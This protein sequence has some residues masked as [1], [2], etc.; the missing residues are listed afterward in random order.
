MAVTFTKSDLQYLLTQIVAAENG[1]PPLNP[2]LAFGLRELA[3]TNNNQLPGQST[4]GSADQPFPTATKQLFQTV[5]VNVDGTPFDYDLLNDGTT[6]TTTYAETN[7]NAFGPPAH[8]VNVVDAAPRMISNLIADISQNNPAAVAVAQAFALQL[9]DGYTA[10]NTNPTGLILPGADGKFGTADDQWGAGADG[11]FGNDDD[12]WG[13]DGLQGTTDD[14]A[15]RD[16]DNLFIGNIVPDA[17]LSAPFNNWMTF[18]GQFFDHGLDLIS[19]GGNGYV[20]IPLDP[21]DPLYVPGGHTNFMLLER[22]SDVTVLPG[23]DGKLGTADD[24]HQFTNQVSP[25]VDQN[26]TYA[27]DGSHNAF[28]REYMIGADGRLHSTGKMLEHTT[29][30]G[31]D[32]IKGDNQATLVDESLDD[33]RDG[34]A[35]WADLKANAL[36]FGL[37][38]TDYDVKNVPL[39]A[40]DAYG[41]LILDNTGH[42]QLLV[43]IAGTPTQVPLNPLAPQTL[44]QIATATGGAVMFTGHAFINDMAH[45]ASPFSSSGAPL[46]AD[47]DSTTGLANADASPTAGFYDNELLDAHYMAGDGR[48]NENIALTTVHEVFHSEHNRLIDQV[49]AMVQAELN[50]GDTAFATDWVLPGTVL[51]PG[52]NI[53]D[54]QWNGERLMQ[55]AKFGTETQYQHLV[56]E[57]FARKIAPTIHLFGNVDIHLD[58]AITSEFANAVYRFGHSMLDENVPLYQMNPDG[59]MKIGLDGKPMLTDM[60]L[61]QAFTNPLAFAASPDIAG[62]VV[63]GTTHQIGSE[64]DEFV[65][66]ALRNNLLGLP[67][68]LAALNIARGRDTGVAPLNLVRAQIYDATHDQTL[69]PYSNWLEFGQFLK[70]PESLVNFIAAY[71]THATITGVTDLNAKRAAALDLIT[72]GLDPMSK[73][74]DPTHVDAY[75]FMH[76]L[77]LYAN[78]VNNAMAVHA[79]WSTGSV[80]GVDNIDLWMGGL[81]EKQN[82]FGG[83]LGST[84]NFIFETQLENLQD[85]DRFYYLP[86]IEG[87]D[88]GQQIENNSFADMIIANTGVKHIS[89]AIFMTPEYTIEAKDVTDNP[90][91]WLKNPVTGQYIVEKLPDGTVHFIG[92]DNFFGNTMVLGGTDGD[93]RLQAGMADDDTVWG[94]GGNDWID[95]GNGDDFLYGGDGDDTFVDSAGADV[96]H[97]NDGNDTVYAG[98]GDDIVFGNDGNDYVE[99]GAGIDDIVGGAGNDILKGGEDDD[100]ILGNEGDDWIEGGDGGDNLVGDTGAPTGQVPLFAANDVLD[101]GTNGDKMVGFSGDD[102]MLGQGGFDKFYG[103]LGFDWASFEKETH[104][105]SVDME[106]RE[107]VANPVAPA[108]DAI[109]DFFIETEAASGSKFDDFIQGTEDAGR[110]AGVFNELQ[111]LDL[112]F[113]LKTFF[114]GGVA[115]DWDT[116]GNP[117]AGGNGFDN[118]NILLGGDGNDVITGR[119]GNDIIDGDAYLHVALSGNGG[120]GSEIIREI[121]WDTT[122]GDVDTAVFRDVMANYTINLTPDENGFITVTHNGTV[123][124]VVAGVRIPVNEGTD[125]LRNIERL[126][127]ADQTISIDDSLTANSLPTGTLTVIGD[128]IPGTPIID[129]VVGSPLTAVS[130]LTDP[131]GLFPGTTVHFQWQQQVITAGGGQTWIDIAG[132]TGLNFTP[133]N[134]Q[135][136]NALRVVESWKDGLGFTET[137]ASPAT[138]LL[139][140]NL[141]VNTAPFLVPQQ[142]LFGL[143]DTNAKVGIPINLLLPLTSVFGDN[144]TAPANLVYTATLS[145]GASLASVG[146]TFTLIPD[147]LG[148]VTGARITGSVAN[149]GAIAIKITATD[150]GNPAIP[151]VDAASLSTTDTFLINVQSA[152]IPPTVSAVQED[153]TGFE[154]INRSGTLLP[155]SDA[156]GPSPLLFK[157]VQGSA[158]NGTVQING[159]TGQFLFKPT[160]DFAGDATFK[161]YVTDGVSNSAQKTVTVHFNAVDDGAA[162]V[163]ITGTAASGGTLSAVIGVDPDGAYDLST[164][165]YQWF[166]DGVALGGWTNNPDLVLSDGDIGHQFSVS[167]KYTDAQGF[168]DS[169]TSV[170]TAPVGVVKVIPT[171]GATTP[172]L[173]VEN[174]LADPDGGPLPDGVTYQWEVST[175]GVNWAAAPDAEVSFDTLTFTPSVTGDPGRYVRVTAVYIDGMGFLNTAMSMAQHY[176]VDTTATNPN[177]ITGLSVSDYI[178]GNGGSDRINAGA[179][180]DFALG[181]AGNDRF[182]ATVGDG[183]DVYDGGAGTDTYDLGLTSAAADVNLVTGIATSADI[184]TDTL[185]N[186]ENV[187][188]SNG[189]NALTGNAGANRL[190]GRGGND[191]LDGGSAGADVLV[192]GT[193]DD[194]YIVSHTGMTLTELAGAAQ[195]VD[196]VQSSI[197]FALGANFENLTLTGTANINGTGNSG[198]NVIIGNSGNNV[199]TGGGGN[200]NIQGGDG[201]DTFAASAPV[202]P[203]TND[204]NDTYNG[205][206]G[207]DTLDLSAV[208]GATIVNL[209]AGTATGAVIG[210]DTLISIENVIG[211]NGADTITGSAVDNVFT[212]RGGGDSISGGAGNDRF[213]ATAADGG[214]TYNGGADFDTLDMSAITQAVTVNLTLASGQVTGAQVGTDTV[215][216]IERFIG[217]SA[218]DV[219][220]AGNQVETFTGGAGADRFVFGSIAAAGNGAAARTVITDFG[221]LVDK[222]DLRPFDANTTVAG[223]Q[224]FNFVAAAGAALAPGQVGFRYEFDAFGQEHT[225]VEGNVRTALVDPTVTDFQID[226]VGHINLTATDFILV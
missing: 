168:D 186:I 43:N 85:G 224:A 210:N 161:Y 171:P 197:S 91:T 205:G 112:I 1:Q 124:G 209:D 95:G 52:T 193:G 61:I 127:F 11:K 20:Y 66:G 10:M 211:N 19:K 226:L 177:I 67:L 60:G 63:Q 115:A 223:V 42:V 96:V 82:L 202:A 24:I 109:R 25:F 3:G 214:D 64:I 159:T 15:P 101:G 221:H 119:A 133:T 130:T 192:G 187:D 80:T 219:F 41:N 206:S 49:K 201:N 17:G 220:T 152:N 144:E 222:I 191:I 136:G 111:N 147:G 189:V 32:G 4:Y 165:T 40:T 141:T 78:D 118:G 183:D 37:I 84:F 93:D 104:G 120:A 128:T 200:D 160:T 55:V 22:A 212:G 72:M 182:I 87:M 156:D 204:G 207:T 151:G 70:H 154:D 148:G 175:D 179:G 170:Q 216:N 8:G 116:A 167:A 26:Q 102:I 194:T 53:A 34:M 73:F 149:P 12:L 166:K 134:A 123:G 46:Q 146:L 6:L 157:I 14:L 155:G 56:F 29:G 44:S 94:D 30:A 132:A 110:A 137:V 39:L 48:V 103:K 199:L 218:A 122:A 75:N 54:D 140:P 213:V 215:S 126:Q 35:T 59:T 65:T 97:G 23:A 5:T 145:N 86:R 9:G 36:K 121:R 88:Y 92:D 138:N 89:A 81:A 105:V 225:I 173:S 153:W 74:G 185:I 28:L 162:D 79:Q 62:Q 142:G 47:T 190:L 83:L 180:N 7:P 13:V 184:G 143:P 198:N 107:F 68:D 195:G 196:T 106:R 69:K 188:G 163:S 71:G 50:S 129:P 33:V 90:A 108:G 217:G 113:N 38:L 181:G 174:S 27:S 45:D 16:F 176:V 158:T 131:D 125:K 203:A 31:V 76:S 114:V 100:E 77:G 172:S 18:F 150:E 57:E 169:N 58:P 21:S 98:I 208:F 178:F 117:I 164:A 139:A 51:T 99:G 2:H 135:L